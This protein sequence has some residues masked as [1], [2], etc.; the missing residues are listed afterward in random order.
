MGMAVFSGMLVATILGVL[1]VPGLF[2]MIEGMGKK[3]Q[4]V[5]EVIKTE[6][7]K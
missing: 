6:E 5:N 2:V 4:V 1:V 7:G 3:K